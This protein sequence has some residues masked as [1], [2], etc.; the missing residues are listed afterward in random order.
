MIIRFGDAGAADIALVGGKAASLGRLTKAGFPVPP[1]FTVT[2]AAQAG[3]YTAHRLPEL[4]RGYLQDLDYDNP[5]RLEEQTARIRARIESHPLPDRL[6]AEI[7]SHY[8]ALGDDAPVAVRSS[9]TAED[10]AEASFAGLHDTY[11]DIVGI[12]AVIDAVRRCWA[13]MWTARATAYR[14]RAGFDHAAA[15]IAVVVQR[16]IPAEVSGVLFTGNPRNSRTDEIVLNASWG[17]GEG[18]VSGIL[19]PD[20]F[21]LALD[22]LKIKQRTLG[23]KE[24]QVVRAPGGMGTVKAVVP[25]SLREAWCLSDEKACALAELGR[26]VMN[27]YGGIPQ[28]IE[29]ALADDRLYLLQSRPVTGTEFTWDEDVDAWHPSPED[30][31]TV[32]TH[33][34]AE[35]FL[36]GGITPLFASMRSWECY[37][38][39]SRFAR[40]YG[41]DELTDVHW[42]KYRRATLYYNADAEKIWQRRMWPAA[43]RDLTNIPPAWQAEFAQTETSLL[44]VARMWARLH[45]SE[46]KYGLLKWFDTTYA[47]ID[48]R[49]EEANGPS[50]EELRRLTDAALKKQ[51]DH[52]VRL[53][54]QFFETLWPGFFWIAGGSLGLLN[55]LVTKWYDGSQPG[56]FQDLITGIPDT[57]LVRETRDLW[58]LA[59]TIRQSKRLSDCLL[60]QRD[61][62]FFAA[63]EHFE[64]GRKFLAD[65]KTFLSAHGHR[66]HQ[67]RD[68]YYQRRCENPQIDYQAFRTLLQAGESRRPEQLEADLLRRR[69]AATGEVISNLSAKPLGGLKAELFKIVLAY[70][71]R[72]LKFRDDERHFLDR[73]TLQKKR[74]FAELGRRMRERGLLDGE[75]DFYFL[76]R[77]ELFDLFEGRASQILCRAKIAARR[78]VFERRN[79]RQEHTP[80]FMQAGRVLNLESRAGQPPA[81]EGTLVGMGTARGEVTGRARLVLSLRDIGRVEKD[82]ILV[83]NSTDPGWM[84][85]FPLIRGLVLET[86]GM[87][88][89][90]A[91]LAREYGLPAVQ[92]RHAIQLIEDG[93]LISING[94][95]GEIRVEEGPQ[96]AEPHRAAA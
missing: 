40:I 44:D 43:L 73:Q 56:L 35:Q 66:G 63:L 74:T 31:N 83:C 67:D 91:C 27:F 51:C 69:L 3:F 5:T 57:A 96:H 13:S 85:V 46:P 48:H 70:C 72:V 41:F 12:D 62:A 79:A 45:V 71:H 19:T 14:Q 80:P 18:I 39:W 9:G 36:T 88:A 25:K 47:W 82:D 11:L 95:T 53:V 92:L 65:Y 90:G 54:E 76:A 4:I 78:R 23:S 37:S 87:L 21:I 10:L 29:W 6:A 38:N 60:Q 94:D 7:A 64:E 52:S 28:D 16:M 24:V 34:W 93:A 86:G 49:I 33:T 68:I 42:F 17:L 1:G 75:D 89:H 84:P 2:T 15:E 59:D 22:T 20:E 50:A 30:E 77:H 55:L 32:W 58:H 8:A 61:S 81:A 26:E